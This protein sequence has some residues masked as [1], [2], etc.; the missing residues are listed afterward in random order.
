[1]KFDEGDEGDEGDEDDKNSRSSSTHAIIQCIERR[2]LSNR[3]FV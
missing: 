1:L 3:Y 2:P